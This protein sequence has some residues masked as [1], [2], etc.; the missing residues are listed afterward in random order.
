MTPI[1]ALNRNLPAAGALALLAKH[2]HWNVR[3]PTFIGVHKLFDDVSSHASG[4]ADTLAE[5]LGYFGQE[6]LGTPRAVAGSYIGPYTV[7]VA[8]AAEHLRAILSVLETL[9]DEFR[10]AISACLASSDQVT[11]DI[12]IE[13][14][15]VLYKD[16]YLVR[17]H[18]E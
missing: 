9:S 16:I 14:C 18:L 11:A 6:A 1:E 17:S 12:F 3:G 8:S 2:A 15:R 10:Q 5:Q 7:G 13:S 4:I